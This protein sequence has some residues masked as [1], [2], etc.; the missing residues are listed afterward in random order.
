MARS[1]W[2]VNCQQH[3]TISARNDPTRWLKVGAPRHKRDKLWL[4]CPFCK[5]EKQT[6]EVK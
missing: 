5:K 2:M 3:G 6:K 4:G 1:A